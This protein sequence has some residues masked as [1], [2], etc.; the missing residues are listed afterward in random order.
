MRHDGRKSDQLRP[1]KTTRGFT[2]T[3]AGSVLWEQGETISA[4]YV[5]IADALAK[6]PAQVPVPR[7]A[8]AV[9]PARFDPAF[10]KPGE[11]LLDQLA[12]ISV[13][14]VDGEVL[15]DLDYF[16]DSRAEVD[17]NVAFT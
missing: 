17:V 6:L 12:A 1:I 3:P 8:P 7:L 13:G 5:A 9:L 2:K 10:Y 14:I 4:A 16:E 11:A 15:L